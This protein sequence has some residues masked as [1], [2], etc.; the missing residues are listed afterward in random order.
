MVSAET[1]LKI[2]HVPNLLMSHRVSDK[3]ATCVIE[4]LCTDEKLHTL[5]FEITI[6]AWNLKPP[7]KIFRSATI[8]C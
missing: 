2:A 4:G 1:P 7:L 6:T 8:I 5:A 3:I